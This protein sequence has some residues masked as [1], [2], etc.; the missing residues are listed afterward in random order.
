LPCCVDEQGADLERRTQ[1]NLPAGL[2]GSLIACLADGRLAGL[3]V[4]EGFG[5]RLRCPGRGL[6]RLV[7]RRAVGASLPAVSRVMLAGAWRLPVRRCRASVPVALY[8][9]GITVGNRPVWRP[10][11]RRCRSTIPAG[12]IPA[13]RL[14]MGVVGGRRLLFRV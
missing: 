2:T 4:G 6:L 7:R 10:L 8:G 9:R 1:C 3:P 11:V 13:S 5:D 12:S 14:A